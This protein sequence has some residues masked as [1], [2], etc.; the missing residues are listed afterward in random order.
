MLIKLKKITFKRVTPEISKKNA[1]LLDSNKYKIFT[2]GDRSVTVAS[3]EIQVIYDN[4]DIKNLLTNDVN[5]MKSAYEFTKNLDVVIVIQNRFMGI[6]GLNLGSISRQCLSNLPYY[7][8]LKVHSGY[9]SLNEHMRKLINKHLKKNNM[10]F[11]QVYNVKPDLN[12]KS[13]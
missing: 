7:I 4:A 3:N 8:V 5:S 1:K 11:G 2:S 6:N 10:F 13:V 12:L 9:E